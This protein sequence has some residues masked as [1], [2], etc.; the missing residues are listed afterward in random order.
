MGS[1]T[2]TDDGLSPKLKAR[3]AGA[4]WLFVIAAGLFAEVFVRSGLIVRGDAA[5]TAARIA[6]SEP[7][8]RL[9][10]A[11]DL[12]GA[13]AY[14]GVSLLLYD[15]LRPV[16]RSLSLVALGFGLAGSTV[17][18]ANLVNMYAP[19]ILI[20]AGGPN[21]L[22]LVFARLHGV[23]YN[24][25]MLFFAVQ[26]SFL[27]WLVLRS[28]FVPRI[29]GILL[30]VEGACSLVHCFGLFLDLGFIDRFDT[31]ILLPGLFAEGGMTLWLLV[32]GVDE[33]KWRDQPQRSERRVAA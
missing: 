31:W 6:A 9:G 22:I 12:A 10:F 4:L 3:I 1:S 20:G 7:L 24:I 30:L 5:A 8:Y 19:L 28:T 25:S 16:S 21:A 2:A 26:V 29:L 32:M 17:M 33:R 18:A 11:A 13:A 15:L 23:G 14:A 27:G